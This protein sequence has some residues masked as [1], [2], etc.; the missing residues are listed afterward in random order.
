MD[1]AYQGHLSDLA[2]RREF[3]DLWKI[4]GWQIEKKR[5]EFVP[6]NP[7]I[8]LTIDLD[9][10]ATIWKEYLFALPA[11]VFEGEFFSPSDYRS[12]EGWTGQ[13]FLQSLA[14]KSGL[15]AIAR[16]SECTGG[17]EDSNSI[18]GNLIRY[19][20]GDCIAFDRSPG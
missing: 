5:F 3:E 8:L 19:G 13:Q 2:R 14:T 9:C 4:L 6:G 11:R 18:L 1:C 17:S 7:K 10:F 15:V 16:E 20:F 12:T